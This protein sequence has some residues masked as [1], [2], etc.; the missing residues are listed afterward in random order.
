MLHHHSAVLHICIA[1]HVQAT[2]QYHEYVHYHNSFFFF[3]FSE[4]FSLL[5]FQHTLEVLDK[6]FEDVPG[7]ENFKAEGKTEIIL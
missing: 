3:S 5:F 1:L 2:C 6:E 4:C 7:F